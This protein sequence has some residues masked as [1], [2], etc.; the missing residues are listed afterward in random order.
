MAK[1]TAAEAAVKVM[2]SEGVDIAFGIPGAAILPLYEGLK[3]SN[4]KHV[5]VRHEEGGSHSAEGY[6]RASGKV[7]INIGTS[8]PA[9]TNMITGLYSAQAD[10]IPILCITGQAPTDKLH[11]EDFQAVGNREYA[12]SRL[13]EV[14]TK[15][16]TDPKEEFD[17]QVPPRWFNDPLP[18]GPHKGAV[19]YDGDVDKLFNE[20]LPAYWKERGWTEDK[21]IPTRKTLKDLGIDDIAGDIADQHL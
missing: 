13:F 18:N 17:K 2:E 20:D 6:A 15:Q 4:I 3:D 7:G 8:G 10:S 19:S 16:L 5:L 21:G 9:G 11:K 14:H 12:L 1:M